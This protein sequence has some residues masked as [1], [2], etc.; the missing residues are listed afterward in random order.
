[1]NDGEPAVVLEVVGGDEGGFE[2]GGG[3]GGRT[4]FARGSVMDLRAELVRGDAADVDLRAE[5]T[6][7]D[8]MELPGLTTDDAT[9]DA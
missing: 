1:M 9:D 2:D 7:D 8:A 5:L 6:R 3:G 4:R